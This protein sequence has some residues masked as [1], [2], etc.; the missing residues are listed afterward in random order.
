V[1][2]E[3]RRASLLARRVPRAD[4]ELGRAYVIHA[5]NGGIG[6]AVQEADGIGYQLHREKFGRHYLFVEIDWD[7]DP[8]Y[9]TAI[10]L[11]ALEEVP[12]TDD[13]RRL[14]WLADQEAKHRTQIDEAWQ[15]VLSPKKEPR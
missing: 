6:V 1:T 11:V 2:S 5:R 3:D 4:V 13:A 15:V 7:D 10:P 8:T 9:G 12:P 14:A